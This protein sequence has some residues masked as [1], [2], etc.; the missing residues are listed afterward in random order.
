MTRSNR[1]FRST[2]AL[3]LVAL[4]ATLGAGVAA[5]AQ[6]DLGSALNRIASEANVEILFSSEDVA[7]KTAGQYEATAAPAAQLS[8]MLSGTGLTLEQARPNV[9]VVTS[10]AMAMESGAGASSNAVVQTSAPPVSVASPAPTGALGSVEGRVTDIGTGAGLG[11]ALVQLEGTNITAV[12]DQRGFYRLGAVPTGDYTIGVEY[13]GADYVSQS[14]SVRAGEE[15]D[16]NL[17][18]NVSGVSG[19]GTETI[20]VQGNRSSFLQALNQQ[21]NAENNKTVISADLLG[22]FPAETVAEA[23]RRVP[24]VTF[25]RDETTGEGNK[26]SVRGI[27]SE[28]INIQ[29][30]GQQLQGTGIERAVDLTGFLADNISQITIQKSLLP[31]FEGTGNGGL[32]QIETKSALDYGD[33]FF[34]AG[35]ER[36]FSGDSAFGDETQFTLTGTTELSDN[37][38]IGATGSYRTTDRRNYNLT[39]IDNDIPVLP[40]GFTSSTTLPF[41]LGGYPFDPEIGRLITSSNTLINDREVENWT[42]SVFAAWDV[43]DS[44]RLRAEYQRISNEDTTQTQRVTNSTFS[45]STNMPIPELGGEERRR[46]YIRAFRPTNGLTERETTQTTDVFSL[47]GDTDWNRWAFD[48]SLGYSVTENEVLSF[49]VN[50]ISNTNTDVFNLF[51]TSQLTINPDSGGTDRI[52][53]GVF[54]LVGDGIP[55][56]AF[57]P[58]GLAYYTDPLTYYITS[59]SQQQR[60]NETEN[61]TLRFSAQYDFANDY[62]NNVKFGFQ[63]NDITRTNSDDVLSNTNIPT[64]TS[65]V[66]LGATRQFLGDFGAGTLSVQDLGDI[67]AAGTVGAFIRSGSARSIFDQVAAFANANAG[68]YRITDNLVSPEV[69]AGAL[70][71]ATTEERRFAAF[72][73]GE[74]EWRDFTVVGGL[75]VE[76]D[77]YIGNAIAAPSI[78]LPDGSNIPRTEL[79]N[80]GLIDFYENNGTTER[81]LPS[82]VVNWRPNDEWVGRLSYNRTIFS[83]SI[84]LINRGQTVII[85]QRQTGFGTFPNSA[86]IREGNPDLQPEVNDN[87]DVGL[88]YYFPNRPAYLKG[89]VFYKNIEANITDLELADNPAD[90]EARIAEYV[91]PLLGSYPDLLDGF[92][93]NTNYFLQRPNNGEG[94]SIYGVE[95]E[96]AI[97]LDFFPENWPGFLENVQLLGNITW[98]DADFPTRVSAR[99]EN[100]QTFTLELDRPLE[101]QSEWAGNFSIAYEDRGFNGRLLYTYQ[102]DRVTAYDEFNL[103]SL[104]PE[105]ETLDFIGSYTF[106]RGAGRFTVF[107]EGDNLLDGSEDAELLR[108]T[109]SFGGEGSPE[110]LFPTSLLFDGG[111]TFTLGVKANF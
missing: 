87:F 30:N 4:F 105:L 88:E 28:G 47:R 59:V 91:Q 41:T 58:A 82:F 99:D 98:T 49:G 54:G 19:Q 86:R 3:G 65:Y 48:Y 33:R 16:A 29:V 35:V 1:R 2:T 42:G 107:F 103:N 77:E 17:T 95:L 101:E 67:G 60:N 20:I 89:A 5:H 90:I 70:S 23:L 11:G 104:V 80:A 43:N 57:S 25:V 78:R 83:P 93:A 75:R 46:T 71:T 61:A 94:G 84:S 72:L 27:T 31:E 62:L 22:T 34:S 10:A 40:A 26:V 81:F 106:D 74:A 21:K 14:L 38:A 97:N 108:G 36:E 9:F 96:G 39:I 85:D 12:T 102:S 15:T 52:V 64:A 37:F 69:S 45:S 109:G 100:G 73:Q 24:G 8:S 51:D 32:I 53:D 92:D 63:Y 18:L 13:I 56:L 44:T 55:S 50:T 66:R 76:L 79:F 7:N 6:D 111:R 68:S 110:F